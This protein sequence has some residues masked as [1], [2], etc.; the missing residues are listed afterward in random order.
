MFLWNKFECCRINLGHIFM[1]RENHVGSETPPVEDHC[2]R[3]FGDEA[4]DGLDMWIEGC[5]GRYCQQEAWKKNHPSVNTCDQNIA[6]REKNR[7]DSNETL[8]LN[9]YRC[10]VAAKRLSSSQ[11]P[12]FESGHTGAHWHHSLRQNPSSLTCVQPCG[13]S[14]PMTSHLLSCHGSRHSNPCLDPCGGDEQSPGDEAKGVNID[15][16]V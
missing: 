7:G 4:R 13:D 1:I 3:G 5:W 11:E 16:W 14:P 6:E 9:S 15:D 10:R 2:V 12:M 8:Y